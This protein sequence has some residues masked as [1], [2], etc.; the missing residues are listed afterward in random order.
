M[1]ARAR[2]SSSTTAG[3]AAL[4]AAHF[5]T[6]VRASVSA[7]PDIEALECSAQTIQL[8]QMALALTTNARVYIAQELTRLGLT[9]PLPYHGEY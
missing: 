1:D 3:G 2:G 5:E 8:A 7:T 6:Q 9:A 4:L